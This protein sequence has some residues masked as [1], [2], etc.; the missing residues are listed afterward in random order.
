VRG[1]TDREW[2]PGRSSFRS[3]P[4]GCAAPTGADS[5]AED[6]QSV[7]PRSDAGTYKKP[8][9][10]L[11]VPDKQPA[12]IKQVIE[13]MEAMPRYAEQARRSA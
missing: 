3:A 7:R 2:R 9:L 12:A 11:H 10:H 13:Q 4:P 8:F 1:R 6:Q 5:S